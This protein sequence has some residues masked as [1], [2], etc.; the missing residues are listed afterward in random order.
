LEDTVLKPISLQLKQE[1]I[2]LS[3]NA[4]ISM[5]WECSEDNLTE[6][7]AINFF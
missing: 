7:T 5:T 1:L 3:T 4:S 2:E 6:Q